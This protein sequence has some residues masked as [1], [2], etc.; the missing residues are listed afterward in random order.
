[1]EENSRRT[2]IE[3]LAEQEFDLDL[4]EQNRLKSESDIEVAKVKY[5][6]A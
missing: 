3:K 1:M 4:E 2:D 5:F 6:F